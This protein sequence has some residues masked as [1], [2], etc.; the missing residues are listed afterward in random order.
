MLTELNGKGG[1]LCDPARKGEMRCPLIIRQTSEDVITGHIA[2]TL[3]V[4]NPRWWLP[5]FLN[6]ALGAA[7]FRRQVFRNLRIDPWVNQTPYPRRLLPW[8][9]GSTQVDCEI[10]WENP[11]TTVFIEAKFRADL[12]KTTANAEGQNRFPSDQL[13]R[14]L[15]VGLY[16]CG[17]FQRDRLFQTR[18][19]DFVTILLSPAEGHVLVD[20][21]RH[22]ETLLAAI[23]HSNQ[24]VGLPREPFLGAISFQGVQDIFRRQRRWLTPAEL[25][26]ADSLIDYLGFKRGQRN[27]HYSNFDQTHWQW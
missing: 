13:V 1:C 3:R 18:P 14:N 20:E 7:R 19:R 8:D 16:K 5:D 9:E 6:T 22:R 25:V 17:Y 24:L 23:P 4:I 12:S 10:S 11:P 26:M 21:Y 2:Q 27:D 15:R